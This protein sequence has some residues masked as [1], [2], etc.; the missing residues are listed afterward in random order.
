MVH[1][2]FLVFWLPALHS[3][4]LVFW[5]TSLNFHLFIVRLPPSCLT[6][7]QPAEPSLFLATLL[8]RHSAPD[9]SC[10]LHICVEKHLRPLILYSSLPR[11]LSVTLLTTPLLAR[12]EELR[13]PRIESGLFGLS[14]LGLRAAVASDRSCEDQLPARRASDAQMLAGAAVTEILR[15]VGAGDQRSLRRQLH[16]LRGIEM[17][18]GEWFWNERCLWWS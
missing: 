13:E 12:G 1:Y 9:R 17:S 6:A 8:P 11:N 14:H 16:C 4:C 5:L 3:R 2:Y 15:E 10:S 18:R 7:V